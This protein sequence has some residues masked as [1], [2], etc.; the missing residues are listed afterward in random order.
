MLMREGKSW[1]E[2]SEE[3][4][5][6]AWRKISISRCNLHINMSIKRIDWNLRIVNAVEHLQRMYMAFKFARKWKLSNKGLMKGWE[7]KP[8]MGNQ[9]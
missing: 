2:V 9:N 4:W 5:W 1:S 8:K 6:I 7:T 3:V